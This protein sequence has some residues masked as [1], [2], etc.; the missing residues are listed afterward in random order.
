M[1]TTIIMEGRSQNEQE[2]S[3]TITLDHSMTHSRVYFVLDYYM[4]FVGTV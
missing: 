4:S 1:M 3:F 2:L